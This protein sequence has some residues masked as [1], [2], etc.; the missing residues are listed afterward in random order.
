MKIKEPCL[1]EVIQER[2][3]GW[4][5]AKIEKEDER[6]RSVEGEQMKKRMRRLL[7]AEVRMRRGR[8]T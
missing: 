8:A 7:E 1:E 4:E 5:G 3:R 2:K 6:G